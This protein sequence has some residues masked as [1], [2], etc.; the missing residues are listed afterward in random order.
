MNLMGRA[1]HRGRVVL[2][3]GA[4]LILSNH[5]KGE[6]PVEFNVPITIVFIQH[7]FKGGAGIFEDVVVQKHI[8]L[9]HLDSGHLA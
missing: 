9:L 8:A 6:G 4:E 2:N 3:N 5:R 7:A 1:G